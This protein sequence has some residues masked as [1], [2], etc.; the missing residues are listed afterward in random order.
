M[1]FLCDFILERIYAAGYASK[2]HAAV[3]I[4]PK[5]ILE[6]RFFIDADEPKNQTKF[7]NQTP[8]VF[9]VNA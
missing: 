2:R 9:A 4:S 6:S 3:V 7:S 1:V 5:S 8:P